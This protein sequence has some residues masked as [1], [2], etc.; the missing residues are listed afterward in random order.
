MEAGTAAVVEL[1]AKLAAGTSAT[2]GNIEASIVPQENISAIETAVAFCAPNNVKGCSR[3]LHQD[4]KMHILK[5]TKSCRAEL[6][7]STLECPVN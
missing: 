2:A 7:G 3:Q 6:P 4:A 1:R 5:P